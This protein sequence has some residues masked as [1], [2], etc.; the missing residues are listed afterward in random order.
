MKITREK[1]LYCL[2]VVPLAMMGFII[3]DGLYFII[4]ITDKLRRK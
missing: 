1:I 3:E 2:L 4:N